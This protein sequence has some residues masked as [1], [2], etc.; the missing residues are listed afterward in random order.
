MYLLSSFFLSITQVIVSYK[1]NIWTTI[2]LRHISVLVYT[3]RLLLLL[4]IIM[5]WEK[6]FLVFYH[7]SCLM[8]LTI[9]IIIMALFTRYYTEKNQIISRESWP[10]GAHLFNPCFWQWRTQNC[11]SGRAEH[12]NNLSRMSKNIILL[13]TYW[14]NKI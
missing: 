3:Q 12:K 9:I 5:K 6:L 13:F 8:I 14:I 1:P 4:H 7:H 11:F 2:L 10:S